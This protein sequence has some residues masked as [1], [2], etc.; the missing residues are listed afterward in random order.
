MALML[1]QPRHRGGGQGGEGVAAVGAVATGHGRQQTR[2]GAPRAGGRRRLSTVVE[3][4][5]VVNWLA[6]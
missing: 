2:L 6:G 5:M 4:R 3:E 1:G